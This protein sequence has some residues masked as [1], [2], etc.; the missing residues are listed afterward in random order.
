MHHET[1]GG[2][3]H[4]RARRR[5]QSLNPFAPV[6]PL[7]IPILKRVTPRALYFAWW[8]PLLLLLAFTACSSDPGPAERVSSP[9]EESISDALAPGGSLAP[10]DSLEKPAY[11]VPAEKGKLQEIE[12]TPAGPY[13]VQHPA[14]DSPTSPTVIF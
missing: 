6:P 5:R 1:V 4:S 2:P 7:G 13:I 10:T 3:R 12:R 14:F 9:G 11:C 8:L